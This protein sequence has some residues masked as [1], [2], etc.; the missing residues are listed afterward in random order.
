MDKTITIRIPN[1]PGRG[2]LKYVMATM[3][4]RGSPRI[5]AIRH[6]RSWVALEGSHRVSA[7]A[8]LGIPITIVEMKPSARMRTD[9]WGNNSDPDEYGNPRRRVRDV[10]KDIVSWGRTTRKVKFQYAKE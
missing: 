5:R 9:V 4:R 6:N 3:K 10:L 2:H 7:A 8:K 1:P